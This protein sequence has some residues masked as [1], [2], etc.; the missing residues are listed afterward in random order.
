MA[1]LNSGNKP[2]LSY[3]RFAFAHND[4]SNYVHNVVMDAAGSIFVSNVSNSA[5][6]PALSAPQGNLTNS[7]NVAR[8]VLRPRQSSNY[9][10][11]SLAPLG[12]VSS[13]FPPCV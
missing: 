11:T 2:V 8:R 7:Q 13:R 9:W 4:T 10:L 12:T 6:R 1:K 3:N 5:A